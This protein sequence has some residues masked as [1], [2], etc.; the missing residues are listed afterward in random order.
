[1][2]KVKL[3][4][5]AD[6]IHPSQSVCSSSDFSINELMKDPNKLSRHAMK[7]RQ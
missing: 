2:L 3:K 4:L 7:K 1:M 5:E 6:P